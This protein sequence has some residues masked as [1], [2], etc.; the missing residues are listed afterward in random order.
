VAESR[1]IVIYQSRCSFPRKSGI[2]RNSIARM[3]AS[4]RLCRKW[5]LVESV[6]GC[7]QDVFLRCAPQSGE[8]VTRNHSAVAVGAHEL[9]AVAP[10]PFG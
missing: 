1:Q 3:S 2:R 7:P 8:T 9:V 6:R 4:A 5:P 10:S